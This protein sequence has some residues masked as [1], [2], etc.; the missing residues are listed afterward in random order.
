[1]M[2]RQWFSVLLMTFLVQNLAFPQSSGWK[3]AEITSPAAFGSGEPNFSVTRDRV[4][5]RWLEP[6]S[7]GSHSLSFAS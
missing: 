7:S 4:Y 3:L 5:M 2:K 1:M 6:A